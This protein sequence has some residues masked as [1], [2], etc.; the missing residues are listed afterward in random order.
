ALAG[1]L[2][3][4]ESHA[5]HVSGDSVSQGWVLRRIA[6]EHERQYR[7]QCNLWS[8]I[9]NPI[10]VLLVGAIVLWVAYAIFGSLYGL[11]VHLS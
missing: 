8:S 6:D 11:V 1:L 9:A 2:T 4:E 10:M 5:I 7:Y 3:P